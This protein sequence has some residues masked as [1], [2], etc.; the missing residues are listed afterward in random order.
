MTDQPD[1]EHDLHLAPPPQK[2]R[3]IR[4]HK[5]RRVTLD[6]DLGEPMPETVEQL[7]ARAKRVK[8]IQLTLGILA[9]AD[10]RYALPK[11]LLNIVLAEGLASVTK[12]LQAELDALLSGP[13]RE[14]TDE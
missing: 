13:A 3:T 6:P 7:L 2:S 4:A 1:I 9:K 8:E 12:A 5:P 14:E 11:Y 10:P